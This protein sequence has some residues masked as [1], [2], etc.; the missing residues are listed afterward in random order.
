MAHKKGQGSTR[1]GRDSK[2]KYRGIK[3]YGGQQVKAGGIIVRQLGSRFRPGVNTRLGK[4]FTLFSTVAGVVR[5]GTSRRVH[6]DAVAAA[7]E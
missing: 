7:A 5:F 3:I 2:P 6:V 1:N 4:D